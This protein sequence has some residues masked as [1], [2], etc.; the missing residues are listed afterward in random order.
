MFLHQRVFEVTRQ[1]GSIAGNRPAARGNG[2][3]HDQFTAC[4]V[5]TSSATE[6]RAEVPPGSGAHVQVVLFPQYEYELPTAKGI[7]EFEATMRHSRCDATENTPT[8]DLNVQES[9]TIRRSA[10]HLLLNVAG[11]GT[12]AS[13]TFTYGSQG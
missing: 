13:S 5:L 7:F 6:V 2:N 9:C 4:R 12:T 3:W 8:G 11:A 1:G 10:G